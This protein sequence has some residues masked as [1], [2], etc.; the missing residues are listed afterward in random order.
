MRKLIFTILILCISII[1][2]AEVLDKI[3]AKV[4]SDIILMS[5]LE[6]QMNQMRASGIKEEMLVPEDVLSY[7]IDQRIM[8]Q[9]AK[10]LDIKIDEKAIKDYASNYIEQLKQQYPSAAAFQSELGKAGLTQSELQKQFEDQ[11]TEN[12]L[13]EELIDKHISANI[14]I[15]EK[16]MREFYE[17]SK[18]TLAVKP[19]SWEL[20]MIMREVLP[21]AEMENQIKAQIDSIYLELQNGADFAELATN[22]SDCPSSKQRGDLG[23]FKKGMMVKPFEDAAFALAV[24]EISPIVKTQFGYHI[25]LLTDRRGE[26]I[27][28][29]H[30]LKTVSPTEEDEAREMNLMQDIRNQILAGADFAEMARKY[31]MDT[32]SAADGGLLG[33]FTAEDIPPLFSAPIMNTAVG[34]P[35]EVLKNE[36]IIYLFIRDKELPQRIYSYEEV[37]EQLESYLFQL[38]QMEAYEKWL[39]QAR[40]DAYIE[41]TL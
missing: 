22:Y 41:I 3:V 2:Y 6:Q 19:V 31:S 18:D 14:E 40:K 5:E 21:S 36:G 32:A 26:E 30:I 28:A 24:G 35:T 27:R 39:E 9:K 38:K 10:E 12:A 7:M 37:K 4:G 8:I 25:I 20:R 15:S 13:T 34:E 11:I 1:N 33:E 29:S 17:T 16:E 23:F